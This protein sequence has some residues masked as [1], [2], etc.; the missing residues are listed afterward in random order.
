MTN[1]LGTLKLAQTNIPR[2]STG[3]TQPGSDPEEKPKAPERGLAAMVREAE[4]VLLAHELEEEQRSSS[5]SSSSG[6]GSSRP[7]L[8]EATA[9]GSVGPLN[10]RSAR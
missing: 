6:G 1:S 2:T 5:S 10:E 3:E 7:T 8:R 9:Q 4:V